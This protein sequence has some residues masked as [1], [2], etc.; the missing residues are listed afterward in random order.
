MIH[1]TGEALWHELRAW[2]SRKGLAW[3]PEP[4]NTGC[5]VVYPTARADESASR[6]TRRPREACGPAPA[7]AP[8]PAPAPSP[9][10]LELMEQEM[11]RLGALEPRHVRR[12]KGAGP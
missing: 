3:A 5:T 10:D 2:C 12:L 7:V 4:N 6:P 9:A 1:G 11:S 8:S